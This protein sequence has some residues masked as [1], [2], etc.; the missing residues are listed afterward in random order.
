[1]GSLFMC[2]DLERF[3]LSHLDLLVYSVFSSN[4]RPSSSFEWLP[5]KDK[6]DKI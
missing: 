5:V 2:A 4:R 3:K 6:S 1:M